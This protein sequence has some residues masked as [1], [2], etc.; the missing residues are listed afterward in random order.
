MQISL[1]QQIWVSVHL[2]YAN[3]SQA[4]DVYQSFVA[5]YKKEID[6]HK[7]NSIFKK[8]AAEYKK[9]EA[10][11]TAGP[12][13][14]FEEHKSSYWLDIYNQN[15]KN[16]L[17]I[18]VGVLIFDLKLDEIEQTLK[19]SKQKIRFVLNQVFKQLVKTQP[20]PHLNT[21][22][23]LVYKK[24][25]DKKVSDFFIRENVVEYSL[26]LL[27]AREERLI[28]DGFKYYPE[29]KALSTLYKSIADNIRKTTNYHMG[30]EDI[31]VTYLASHTDKINENYIKRFHG[32]K[33][34]KNK[35]L[36]G[37]STLGIILFVIIFMRPRW[38]K[39]VVENNSGQQILLQE[40]K[41]QLASTENNLDES[42]NKVNLSELEVNDNRS[43]TDNQSK[44]LTTAK[45]VAVKAKEPIS[46]PIKSTAASGQEA[47]PVASHKPE[48]AQKGGLYRGTIEVTDLDQ[49][50]EHFTDKI[51]SLGGKKAGQVQLGWRKNKNTSY[52][53]FLIANSNIDDIKGFLEKFGE[54]SFAYEDHPRQVP[55]GM[56]RIIL[57]IKKQ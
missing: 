57:E 45:S 40:V 15:L 56:V 9:I 37:G 30:S 16:P 53:H 1:N 46:P 2:L 50:S 29:Y 23:N 32:E 44:E 31:R 4:L 3:S 49:V 34:F 5:R 38:I 54:L 14:V 21:N 33:I 41:P 20:A 13:N 19:I 17:I 26:G 10:V 27:T 39:D 24:M 18:L 43:K 48:V 55:E 42:E 28:D 52:Y 35:F 11:Q 47:A 25:N 22:K 51:I 6:G 36:V 7:K 8:L 12:F